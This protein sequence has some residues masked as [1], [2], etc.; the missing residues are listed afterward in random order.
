[1]SPPPWACRP[2]RPSS[3]WRVCFTGFRFCSGRWAGSSGWRCR[4]AISKRDAMV[5][6]RHVLLVG[7]AALIAA[8]AAAQDR[9]K[10]VASFSILGDLVRNV[11][12]DRL[13]VAA[14]VGPN[15]DAH[16]FSPTPA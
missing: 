5:A 2:A 15:S 16:A 11:G 6:W 14:L 10:A 12:G 3:W 7:L 9:I 4:A 1:L 8:P 13:E